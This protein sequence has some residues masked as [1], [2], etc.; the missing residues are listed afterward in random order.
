MPFKTMIDQSTALKNTMDW[1]YPYIP[2]C[3][4]GLYL[5]SLHQQYMLISFC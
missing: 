5:L 4:I 3:L 1:V 2:D